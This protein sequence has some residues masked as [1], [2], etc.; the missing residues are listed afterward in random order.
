LHSYKAIR[1]D[2]GITGGDMTRP[3]F[4]AGREDALADRSISRAIAS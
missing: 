2:D 1:L 4:L 3:G